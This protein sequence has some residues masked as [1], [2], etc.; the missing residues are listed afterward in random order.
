MES[1]MIDMSTFVRAY[2]R[3]LTP[4]AGT[5]QG[6]APSVAG[7]ERRPRPATSR[8]DLHPRTP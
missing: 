6:I 8:V 7:L 4:T 3:S 1:N 2:A 5:F